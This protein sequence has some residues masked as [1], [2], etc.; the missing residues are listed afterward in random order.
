MATHQ[1]KIEKHRRRRQEKQR[2]VR[3]AQNHRFQEYLSAPH[4]VHGCYINA[5]WRTAGMAS[6]FVARNI[7]RGMVS[8][9]AF[10][11][12]YW[13]MGLKDAWGDAT[14][15]IAEFEDRVD[16]MRSQLGAKR[17]DLSTVRHIVFGGIDVARKWGSGCPSTMNAGPG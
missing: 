17:V 4:E 11:V 5:D 10:L 12:D 13:G 7:A 3:V 15:S 16:H 1:K 9:G 8:F 6:I 2:Q 14:A